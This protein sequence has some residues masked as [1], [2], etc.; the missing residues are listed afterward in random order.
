MVLWSRIGA[1]PAELSRERCRIEAKSDPHW[2][3]VEARKAT[4]GPPLRSPDPDGV[5]GNMQ[6]LLAGLFPIDA[7]AEV[8]VKW[9]GKSRPESWPR[10]ADECKARCLRQVGKD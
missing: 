4:K 2:V 8:M 7:P 3:V 6:Y 9:N 10:L 5:R 1:M